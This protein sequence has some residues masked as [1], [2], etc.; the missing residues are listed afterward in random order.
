MAFTRKFL[1]ALGIEPEK[2]DEII[3][4]HVEVVEGL[5]K[6]RDDTAS[7][8]TALEEENNKL[9]SG[10]T[11]EMTKLKKE[12]DDYKSEVTNR[13]TRQN[14]TNAY[15]ELL[16]A[17]GIP[18]KRIGAIIKV[19]DVDSLELDEKG[20]LKDEKAQS[21]RIKA[22]WSD[23]IETTAVQ[24]AVTATPPTSTGNGNTMTKD[25]ILAIKDTEARQKAIQNNLNLFMKGI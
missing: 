25:E 23:F 11:D 21:E 13:E 20:K 16:R 19:T 15:T 8:I 5:K 18:E 10:N 24:G 12:F 1:T 17:N 14:K 6:E 7:R 3:S 4:A 22:D 9:K 2:I